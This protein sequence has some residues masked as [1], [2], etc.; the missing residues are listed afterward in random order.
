MFTIDLKSRRFWQALVL[1][2]SVIGLLFFSELS[3]A[4]ERWILTP[5][6]IEYWNSQQ[7]PGL[8]FSVFNIQCDDDFGFF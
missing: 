3:L 6:Q 7:R 1:V 5:D 4:H 8:F 2:V